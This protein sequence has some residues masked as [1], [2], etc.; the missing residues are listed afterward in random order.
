MRFPVL[1]SAVQDSLATAS[2]VRAPSVNAVV[3][4]LAGK[5]STSAFTVL[6]AGLVPAP[7]TSDGTKFLR[8]DGTWAIPPG[9][10][11]GGSLVDGNYGDVTVSGSGTVWSVNNAAVAFSEI[12]S[13]PTTLAGYGIVDAAPLVHVGA[14]GGAH[15]DVV[16]SGASGFMTGAQAAKLAG[17][18][19]NA[20]ANSSDAVLLARANHTGQQAASTI[21]DFNEALMDF[22]GQQSVPG[23]GLVAGANV[24]LTYNDGANTLTISA[25]TV[26]GATLADGD[27]GDVT[28]SSSGSVITID[29]GVVTL[30]KMAN[31]N[32]DT[33]IGRDTAGTGVPE[34]L[35]LTGGLE[36]TG[37]G[38]IQTSAFTGDVTKSAGGTS[39]SIAAGAV[40]YAK[41]QNIAT[42]SLVG[43]DT[44]G[45]GAPEAIT[46]NA[47]LEFTGTSAIQRA[48]LTGDVTAGAGSN[49]T[50]I[51]AGA[52]TLAKMAN[53][54]QDQVI[55]R[56]SASTGVPETFTVTAPARTVLDDLSTDAM[57]NTLGGGTATGTGVVVR[58]NTPTLTTPNIGAAT[59]TSLSLGGGTALTTTNRTGTGNLVLATSPTLATPS[60]SGAWTVDGVQIT[61]ASAMGALAVDVT[62]ALNTKSISADSTFTFTGSPSTNG[63]FSVIVTNTDVAPHAV[64]LPSCFN[65]STGT[66]AA[67]VVTIQA[68]GKAHLTFRYDGSA[69]NFYGDTGYIDKF[70]ATAAPGVGDDIADGYGPGSLWLNTTSNLAYICESNAAGAAV[71]NVLG[72][73]VSD[74]DYGDITVSGGVWTIDNAAV[75]LA[76][77]A[78]IA[79]D[80][81]IGRDTTGTGVPEAITVTGGIEFSGSG[82]IRTSAFTGDVTK[83]AGG[84]ALTIA[85]S[86][87]TL[88]KM[89]DIA[90]ARFIGRVTAATGVPESLTGT[91]ATTL[92][93]V[94]T[95]AL[96]GLAPA[97]GGGT[98]NFLRADGTWAAPAGGGTVTNTG[99]NLTANL[100]VLGAGTTDT[101]VAA[102][103]TTDGTSKLTLGVAGASVGG[104]LMANATS[105]TVELRPVTGALGTAVVSVPAVTGTMYVSGG[106]DVAVA[107]GGTGLSSGT[108]GGVLA[109]TASGTLASSGALTANGLVLGGGAG[110]APS[111]VAGIAS[112]GA[113]QL[114]LGVAG[115]SVGSVQLRNATS[116][117]ITIQPTTGA[118]GTVTLTAP[119]T[120][121]TIGLAAQTQGKH[122]VPVMAGGM[123]PSA[124][125]GCA[126]LA[127]VASAA[128]QPDIV[129]LDFDATTQ[130]FAQFSIPMPESWNEGTVTFQA[131]WSHPSTTTNFGVAW[132]LQGLAVSDNEA[133]AQAYGT[134]VVVTDTGGTTNNVYTTAESSAITIAGTPAN[135]DTVFFRVARVPADAG[136]T[137]AVDA[138]LHGIR[139]YF[140][141]NADT[142]A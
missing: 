95:T 47:T 136:D 6:A 130:E 46:L 62:K 72:G 50:T 1:P 64:T 125:G 102:G 112:D 17:I 118:L 101:K 27:Y 80:S 26:G 103:F 89:A 83:T 55:G 65:M 68:S 9:G 45:S 117:S 15:A 134:A 37:A 135:K 92:L 140:T 23:Q 108:S 60:L 88:A 33:I 76:K 142:D 127:T 128:N 4:A 126:A 38:G 24:T 25:A 139:L 19:A 122:M 28:A 58:A 79:T 34:A 85:N 52:V 54:A 12:A 59:G 51:A 111:T 119:A 104:L 70:N 31:L 35:T 98:T 94:F 81:L 100:L 21:S 124:T 86:A 120:T 67:H 99:G 56:V 10:G 11:G 3:A 30:A 114:Q 105:G 133:I 7:G 53:L 22:L 115:S 69:Y 8:D 5:A 109:F 63:W 132:Q 106:T 32:T 84:T 16:E 129:T 131:I 49:T 44:A 42:D 138:R 13:K 107:D 48:A 110:A 96:K 97:S 36:F 40:T 2:S 18:S 137:M 39:L 82:S 14:G 71:W 78:N 91:Q 73:G 57:L 61:T 87:V 93:D 77:M 75:T 20:T 90:T 116:G 41:F 113:S 74:S 123:T 121:G 43:R 141:T 66:T 29:N